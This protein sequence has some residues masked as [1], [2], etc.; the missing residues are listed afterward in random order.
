MIEAFV[1]NFA[2]FAL[3]GWANLVNATK[4][5]VYSNRQRA[6]CHHVLLCG[7]SD[8]VVDMIFK[9]FSSRQ[10]TESSIVAANINVR[11]VSS[12]NKGFQAQS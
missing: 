1:R 3:N 5:I 10:G 6:I 2:N 9:V 8:G 7:V 4:R 11:L 12:T